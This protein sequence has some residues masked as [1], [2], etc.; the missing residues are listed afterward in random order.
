MIIR[1]I[2]CISYSS[3]I[4][5]V[6]CLNCK[7]YFSCNSYMSCPAALAESVALTALAALSHSCF[8]FISIQWHPGVPWFFLPLPCLF[9]H[10]LVT[11]CCSFLTPST[12]IFILFQTSYILVFLGYFYHYDLYCLTSQLHPDVSL[13]LLPQLSLLPYKQV[14]SWFS[15]VTSPTTIFIPLE[16]SDI[17][18]FLCYFY[19][20]HLY[21]ITN[22]SH[23]D[24][25]S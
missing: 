14:T 22:Q 17:L 8:H 12:A 5:C 1:S 16:T 21:S 6:S 18:I 19:H 15:F 23:L 7:S 2:S 13:L 9:R 24:F 20:C 11:S 10:K 4:C 25:P 3:C